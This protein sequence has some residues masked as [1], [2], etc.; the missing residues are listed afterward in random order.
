MD[1]VSKSRI[2]GN[3][4]RWATCG[5]DHE[6]PHHA[7]AYLLVRQQ[8]DRPRPEQVLAAIKNQKA[9]H[10]N[11]ASMSSDFYLVLK[12]HFARPPSWLDTWVIQED[13]LLTSFKVP[14]DCDL[15]SVWIVDAG[16]PREPLGKGLKR[17]TCEPS[18]V[19]TMSA[20]AMGGP[21][22]APPAV[23]MA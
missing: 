11:S 15:S 16:C 17:I 14:I 23:S 3:L 7:A 18:M 12:E 2:E 9:T 10:S 1:G 22:A 8:H 6:N 20:A 5:I 21:P 13:E 4:R 19:T